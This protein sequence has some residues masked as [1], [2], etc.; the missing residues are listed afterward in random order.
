MIDRS[1]AVDPG[2]TPLHPTS[3]T[4]FRVHHGQKSTL[5]KL[6]GNWG[7]RIDKYNGESTQTAMHRYQPH[8]CLPWRSDICASQGYQAIGSRSE[9]G[10][11][12][13]S[14]ATAQPYA[15]GV[16]SPS[17]G[18][19]TPNCPPQGPWQ[20]GPSKLPSKQKVE[21]VIE[22]IRNSLLHY[23]LDGDGV[24]ANEEQRQ[25]HAVRILQEQLQVPIILDVPRPDIGLCKEFFDVKTVV[26]SCL[27]TMSVTGVTLVPELS[28]D[29]RELVVHVGGHTRGRRFN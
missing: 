13:P 26:E 15:R 28:D 8:N 20:S 18:N 6:V 9:N 16:L 14:T 17:P 29:G 1:P 3:G 4:Q 10:S 21:S 11:T 25:E 12:H 22:N 23:F 19:F 7:R 27:E 24:E 2:S 5:Q